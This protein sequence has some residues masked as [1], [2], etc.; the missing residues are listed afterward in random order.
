MPPPP[1]NEQKAPLVGKAEAQP[2]HQTPPA[3]HPAAAV[4]PPA[5]NEVPDAKTPTTPVSEASCAL[6]T[7]QPSPLPAVPLPEAESLPPKSD[8][9]PPI[10]APSPPQREEKRGSAQ[11]PPKSEQPPPA[12]GSPTPRAKQDSQKAQARHRMARE[13]REERAKHLGKKEAS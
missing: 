7:R 8:R 4:T 2:G 6:Q 5:P 13:R 1:R 11:L 9:P 10:G 12:Q 3:F